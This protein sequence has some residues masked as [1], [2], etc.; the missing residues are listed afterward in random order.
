VVKKWLKL[1]FTCLTYAYKWLN[2]QVCKLLAPL[3]TVE[4]VGPK[5]DKLAASAET[6]PTASNNE[7]DDNE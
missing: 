2:I 5:L 6:A 7:E 1:N 4:Q 3:L